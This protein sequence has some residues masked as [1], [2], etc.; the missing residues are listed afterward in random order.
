VEGRARSF[1]RLLAAGDILLT[2]ASLSLADVLRHVLPFGAQGS[3]NLDWL[4][5]REYLIVG[6]T[7]A[8][9]L[10]L[11]KVYDHRRVLRVVAEAR[12]I[13]PAVIAAIAVLFAAFFVLKVE[14]LSRL[15]FVYFVALNVALLLNY[16]WL[17]NLAV[18]TRRLSTGAQ[19]RVIIVGAGPVGDRVSK[20][21]I[22]SPWTGF[23]IVGFTDDNPKKLGLVLNG[24][25]V[26]GA[27]DDLPRLLAEHE[28]DEV[29]LALP[30]SAYDRM[31]KIV[32][33]LERADVRIHLVPD[34]FSLV[35]VRAV[36]QDVLGF[37]MIA[38]RA[39][40]ITGLDRM[41]KRAF[42]VVLGATALVAMGPLMVVVA[43]AVYLDGGRPVFFAQRRVGENGKLFTMYKF[44]TMVPDAEA[45]IEAARL[46][47]ESL[48]KL[49]KPAHDPRITMVG[50]ML[51][52]ASLDELPQLWNVLRGEMSLVG[53]RPELPWVVDQYESW[54]RQRLA[55]MP[56]MT[57][58]WQINGRGVLP[59]RENVEYDLYYIRNYSTILDLTI[60]LRTLWVVARGKGA[61]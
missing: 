38:V 25:P 50:R 2:L 57:G 60:L 53:P 19:A 34:V 30:M 39:P 55:V 13:I 9:F 3:E 47:G 48:D 21:I 27:S 14:F 8:F 18:R 5:P 59:L 40:V 44:R 37:P 51:R 24:R 36:V 42:D 15:L 17:L 20:A 22:E 52:R 28:I 61:Y 26:M 12:S 58:W 35:S 1:G 4:T 29:V 6:L 56:G 33:N 10:R 31:R 41:V 23:E 49:Y 45:R 54:Q 11:A 32:L 43:L 7:W 16:R 46:R